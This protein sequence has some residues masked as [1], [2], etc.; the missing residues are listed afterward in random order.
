M[1]LLE[2]AN[3]PVDLLKELFREANEIVYEAD[4]ERL[5]F[6]VQ[7]AKFLES[8][9]GAGDARE[10]S[11]QLSATGTVPYNRSGFQPRQHRKKAP[12]AFLLRYYRNDANG[13]NNVFST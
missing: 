7:S 1:S 6:S 10:T 13:V 11:E 8:T 3:E 4:Q 9:V 2:S 12:E 5:S